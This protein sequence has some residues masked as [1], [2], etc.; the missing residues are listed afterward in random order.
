MESDIFRTR[1]RIGRVLCG[2]GEAGLG[3]A[4]FVGDDARVEGIVNK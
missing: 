4:C 3:D 1:V 2:G